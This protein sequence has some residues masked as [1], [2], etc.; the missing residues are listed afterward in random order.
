MADLPRHS[1]WESATKRLPQTSSHRIFIKLSEVGITVSLRFVRPK[2][3]YEG[4][5]LVLVGEPKIHGVCSLASYCKQ[6]TR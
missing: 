6:M 3:Y 1:I 4:Q 5:L 2:G